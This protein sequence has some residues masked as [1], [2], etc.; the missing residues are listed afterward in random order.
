[1][2]QIFT[3]LDEVRIN[4]RLNSA[5]WRVNVV[6]ETGSTQDDIATRIREGI[7]ASGD[8]LVAEYQSK[9]RGRLQREFTAPARSAL[10][11]SAFLI[12]R[13][14]VGSWG[15]LPLLA[16]QAVHSAI[17]P[18]LKSTAN[19]SLK[20]PNDVLLNGKKISGLLCERVNSPLGAGVI[21]G[22]GINVAMQ[23]DQLPVPTATSLALEGYGE[24]SR[25]DL[26]VSILQNFTK[27]LKRWEVGDQSLISEYLALSS[28][29]G[30]LVRIEMPAGVTR[31]AQAIGV[32]S[33]GSLIL[34]DQSVISVGDVVHLH[35]RTT[36]AE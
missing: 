30:N 25:E 32:E 27:L 6:N 31:E 16:G 29:V 10:L 36:S 26:L 23:K 8:V 4:N 7:G 17:T 33:S 1:V 24:I 2:D 34:E 11:F 19:L 5:Y 35:S 12:P 28:T 9:G 20:W 21:L 22:I 14:S 3:P 15:W 18:Y 13:D